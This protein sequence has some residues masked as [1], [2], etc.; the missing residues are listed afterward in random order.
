IELNGIELNSTQAAEFKLSLSYLT[1]CAL[2]DDQCITAYDLDGSP[3]HYCGSEGLD[4]GWAN[5]LP[6]PTRSDEVAECVLNRADEDG[7]T[8]VHTPV[9]LE[10]FKLVLRYLVECALDSNESVTIYNEYGLPLQLHG[11]LGLAPEWRSA[12]PTES[13]ERLVSACL[14]ARSNSL[15]QPVQLSLRGG[16][17]VTQQTERELYDHHEGAFFADLFTDEPYINTCIVSGGGLSGRVCTEGDDC[18]F[19]DMGR[20]DDICTS[21]DP[22]EGIYN[23]CQGDDKV[24]NTFL[25]LGRRIGFGARHSCLK[26]DDGTLWCWGRNGSGEVGIGSVSFKEETPIEIDALGDD[27]VE[28]SSGY[29]HTCA[30]KRNG[31]LWCWGNNVRGQLGDG[32]THKRTLPIHLEALSDDVAQV[33]LGRRHSCA[34]KTDGSLWCWGDNSQG[35]LGDG[36]RHKR[37]EPTQVSGLDSGIATVST[38]TRA[39]STCAVDNYGRVSCWGNN[40]RGQLGDGSTKDRLVPTPVAADANGHAFDHVTDLCS[41]VGHTCARKSD[42][43]VWCW[44]D[45]RRGQLG[46]GSVYGISRRPTPVVL[47]ADV[48]AHGLSCGDRH[49]CA[50][51]AD[52][53]LQCWGDNSSGQ[54]GD[55]T[56]HDRL[57]PV[58]VTTLGGSVE[59]VTAAA[60]HT[61]AVRT[62]NS[63]WCWGKDRHDVLF[64]G[65]KS[66]MPVEIDLF[67]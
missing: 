64:P 62:D 27:V 60:R 3:L 11:S 54:L 41:G 57:A 26:K 28:V 44:G 42:G 6:D 14:A 58:P 66:N 49:T 59:R 9:K 23:N 2:N 34:V 47:S 20:C 7:H 30:R 32:T 33:G 52:G 4:P 36:T 50:V 5:G 16:S 8:V 10:S 24:I 63:L 39:S 12:A 21:Y 43:T 45:N 13:G 29:A 15:G 51:T 18:G 55:G 25:S 38:G 46:N 1:E 40:G 53:S 56:F 65:N 31:A 17:I 37:K 48:Q 19:T 61:C 67:D 35:Q 22:S